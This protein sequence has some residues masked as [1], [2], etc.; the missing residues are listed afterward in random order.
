MT[1]SKVVSVKFT[2]TFN[3]EVGVELYKYDYAMEDGTTLTAFHKTNSAAVGVGEPAAYEVKKS[4]ARG[5]SGSVRKPGDFSTRSSGGSSQKDDRDWDQVG[6]QW[7]V[8]AAI[9]FMTRT[10][11][12]PSKIDLPWLAGTA[13]HMWEMSQDFDTYLEKVKESKP[14]DGEDLPF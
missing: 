7:A 6:R 12:D 13:K 9:Q 3:P 10:S 5:N 4:G 8:N 11:A 14:N 2:G 1:E